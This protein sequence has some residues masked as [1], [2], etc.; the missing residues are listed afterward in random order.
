MPEN[1]LNTNVLPKFNCS[2]CKHFGRKDILKSKNLPKENPFYAVECDNFVNPLLDCVLR[3]FEGHS[4]QPSHSQT[5]NE[6]DAD[7]VEFCKFHHKRFNLA[8]KE[9][10]VEW[11][12]NP[13]LQSI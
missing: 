1:T 5:L 11:L 9:Q 6:R 12:I 13:Y 8:N 3:G 10:A 4:E 2:N 7:L